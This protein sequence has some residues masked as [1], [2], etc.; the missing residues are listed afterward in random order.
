MDLDASF[1]LTLCLRKLFPCSLWSTRVF[2]KKFFRA[3]YISH[4]LFPIQGILWP[5]IFFWSSFHKFII[6]SM[7]LISFIILVLVYK[8]YTR[9]AVFCF[10]EFALHSNSIT[11]FIYMIHVS[12]IRKHFWPFLAAS[13]VSSS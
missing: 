2:T 12:K 10:W 4:I 9:S 6:V 11:P 7:I 3:A 1:F 8:L 5:Y 13:F